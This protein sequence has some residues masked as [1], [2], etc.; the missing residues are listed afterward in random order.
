[1]TVTVS[2]DHPNLVRLRGALEALAGGDVEPT[3]ALMHPDVVMINDIGAG[4]WR[5]LRG[6]DAVLGFWFAFG[7]FFAGTFGQEILAGWGFDDGVV[8]LVHERGEVNGAVFDNRAIYQAL[9]GPDGRMTELRTM[10][11][12][13]AGIETFWGCALAR[14]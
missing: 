13:R 6:R 14:R 9:L 3:V 4:P 8:L 12:D 2:T 1:M 7:G 5:E 10:D 11:M